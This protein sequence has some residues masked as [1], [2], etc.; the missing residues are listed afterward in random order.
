MPVPTPDLTPITGAQA[1]RLIR[2][3]EGEAFEALLERANA[4]R[5]AAM[6]REVTLCGITNAKSGRC[7]EDCSFCSQSAHYPETGAP[8][9]AMVSAR[10]MADQAKLA[11][12]AGA[13]EFSIVASG[14]KV[15]RESELTELEEAFRL[16]SK[17]A[18]VMRC[19]SLGLM[20]KPELARLKAAGMQSFHHNLESS[21]SFYPNVCTTHTFE[22]SVATVKAAKEVGLWTCCGGIFGMGE[23]PD[24]RVELAETLQSL[25]VDSVPVNF[26]NPRPGTPLAQVQAITPRECLATVAVFRLMMPRAHLFVMGG[27]EAQLGELQH[28]IF[29]AGASGTMV[30]N[31]LTSAGRSPEEVVAMIRE[32]GLQVRG[33]MDG[34]VAWRFQGAAPNGEAAWNTR[35]VTGEPRRRLPVVG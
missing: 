27:R 15:S 1:R 13:R 10:E 22:Q 2:C 31:Y 30:G 24:Q 5:E 9:Y 32:Q 26:L 33:P 3:T 7:A 35:A 20:E 18:S 16:M 14:T 6:G 17:E 29:K 25:G 23:T 8:E 4:V 34:E 21:A 12:A 11:E 28:L 19:A